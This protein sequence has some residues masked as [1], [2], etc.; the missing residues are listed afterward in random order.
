M[1]ESKRKKRYQSE[2][3]DSDKYGDSASDEENRVDDATRKRKFPM[4][5]TIIQ[6][7]LFLILI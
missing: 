5:N 1:K 4:Y 6:L 3:Y 7:L 2:Y